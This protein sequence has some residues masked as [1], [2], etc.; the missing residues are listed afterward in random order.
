MA[1]GAFALAGCATSA[2]ANAGA[3]QPAV[4]SSPSASSSSPAP[5]GSYVAPT[6]DAETAAACEKLL[7][8]QSIRDSEGPGGA[9]WQQI[10]FATK[11]LTEKVS[12]PAAQEAAAKSTEELTCGWGVP[13]SDTGMSI[14]VATIPDDARATLIDALNASE[15]RHASIEGFDVYTFVTQGIGGT[16]GYAFDTKGTWWILSGGVSEEGAGSYLK[17]VA[18]GTF[19]PN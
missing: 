5:S 17:Q 1:V 14:T 7:P 12:G 8:L 15:Y 10:E 9:A 18:G 2:D 6:P 19:P 11:P 3:S 4:S 16:S 13:Q